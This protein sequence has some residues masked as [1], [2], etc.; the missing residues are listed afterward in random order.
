MNWKVRLK[1]SKKQ[2]VKKQFEVTFYV[3]FVEQP[4]SLYMKERWTEIAVME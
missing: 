2:I 3:S 1:Y 4:S